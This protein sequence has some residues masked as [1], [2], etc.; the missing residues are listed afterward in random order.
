[1]YSRHLAQA[2]RP[3]SRDRPRGAAGYPARISDIAAE[4]RGSSQEHPVRV[5]AAWAHR[6]DRPR[7]P[8]ALPLALRGRSPRARANHSSEGSA[9]PPP[10]PALDYSRCALVG[11]RGSGVWNSV[12]RV[13]RILLQV[14]KLG[15]EVG[16]ARG[17]SCR[18]RYAPW[19]SRARI[20]RG[21]RLP[22]THP[23]TTTRL[24]SGLYQ[25]TYGNRPRRAGRAV[26]LGVRERAICD[27]RDCLVYRLP[28]LTAEALMLTVIPVL[29]RRQVEP[30]GSTKEN[31]ERQRGGA[32]ASRPLR[33]Q[34]RVHGIGI[35]PKT[36]SSHRAPDSNSGSVSALE[37]TSGGRAWARG[38]GC[39]ARAA[40]RRAARAASRR[41]PA[42]PC[43]GSSPRS[44]RRCAG[45]R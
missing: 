23:G 41:P 12:Q 45:S 10:L 14:G 11:Q 16:V 40:S 28:K 39:R 4:G 8:R 18:G 43:R 5:A 29:D 7:R 21:S 19:R 24:S 27:T 2:P 35:P 37:F 20:S 30:C 34:V 25:S 17:R 6:Q 33:Q 9:F 44:R 26:A 13:R 42:W 36:G 22:C 31:W 3:A 32:G 38:R 1:M 15:P